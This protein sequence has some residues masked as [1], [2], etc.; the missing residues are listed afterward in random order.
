MAETGRLPPPGAR[1]G[2]YVLERE[3]GRGGMGAVYVGRHATLGTRRA[4]KVMLGARPTTLERFQREA[5]VLAKVDHPHVVRIHSADAQ[6]GLAY[7][8]LDLVEGGDLEGALQGGP[9]EVRR[10]AEVGAAIAD[11]LAHLHA[12]GIVHRDLKPGNILLRAG[13]G[14]PV[15]T[16]FGIVR[17]DSEDRLTKSQ[18]LLGSPQYMAPE[19]ITAD[20]GR[21]G[22]ASDVFSLGVVLYQALTGSLPFDGDSLVSLTAAIMSDEPSP[23]RSLRP[24]L[25]RDV[26]AILRL[27]L[28]K[29][30]EDRPTAAILAA[31]LRALA[32]GE[33]IDLPRGSSIARAWRRTPR[34]LRRTAVTAGVC[35][36]VT[37]MG[38]A[39]A[40]AAWLGPRAAAVGAVVALRDLEARALTPW[41]LGVTGSPPPVEAA[42]LS[43]RA[44]AL[45][46]AVGRLPAAEAAEAGAGAARLEAHARLLG[47]SAADVP[48]SLGGRAALDLV[49]DAL[50]LERAGDLRPALARVEAALTAEPT[51]H[52]ARL[53]ALRLRATLDPKAFLAGA[54]GLAP[55]VRGFAAALAPAALRAQ[56][57][58]P[59]RA[60]PR[61]A[62]RDEVRRALEA[63][64]AAAQELGVP[65][66]GLAAEKVRLVD[67]DVAAWEELLRDA[68]RRGAE[69]DALLRLSAALGTAPAARPGPRLAAALEALVAGLEAALDAADRRGDR[70][71][72]SRALERLLRADA[73]ILYEL[74][75]TRRPSPRLTHL[76]ANAFHLDESW[77]GA[78]VTLVLA[79]ARVGVLGRSGTA[80]VRRVDAR[81]VRQRLGLYPR[82]R[83]LRFL[84]VCCDLRDDEARRGSGPPFDA[85]PGL[86]AVT[87]DGLLDDLAPGFMG[88]AWLELG[89]ALLRAPRAGGPRLL[90]EAVAAARAARPLVVRASSIVDAYDVEAAALGAL[91]RG[92]PAWDE[93]VALFRA[94]A[95]KDQALLD[96][97]MHALAQALQ[98]RAASH[99]GQG[100][101]DEAIADAEEAVATQAGSLA[102][103]DLG[104][105]VLLSRLLRK[106]GRLER[107]REVITPALDEGIAD[108]PGFCAEAVRVHLALDDR[109][110]AASVLEQ[111]ERAWPDDAALKALRRELAR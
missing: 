27:A 95:A 14:A 55:E 93:A 47:G 96:D 63:L 2:D 69:E 23:P 62:S 20:L 50:L 56:A 68:A 111:G 92:E 77:S 60:A 70:A 1:L 107:A 40:Q 91:G 57:V 82:S 31:W 37:G 32:A 8:V 18:T 78:S 44:A 72:Q 67:E 75:P 34:R 106:Q 81:E 5:R 66:D 7:L 90:E 48:R 11:A 30:P 25:P 42:E 36:V 39:L 13:D 64:A 15:L 86:R 103:D 79:A 16:D 101:V 3:L 108:S 97:E 43:A 38:L 35:V 33:A 29:A 94:R 104:M 26:D 22:P 73:T 74:D 85:V 53:L 88:E 28:E 46:A 61:G 89:Q 59:L 84:A 87:E 99:E 52:P 24:D 110:A 6:G 9:L 109:A 21:I 17:D 10:A 76:V 54:H 51:L 102:G 45:R 58:A 4:V 80:I 19:Q 12:M 105:R 83:A 71:G 100:R 49:V 41:A 98:R 65:L